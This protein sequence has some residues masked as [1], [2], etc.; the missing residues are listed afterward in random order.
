MMKRKGYTLVQF[1]FFMLMTMA[2]ATLVIDIGFATLTRRQMQTA[3][4][5]AAKEALRGPNGPT[6]AQKDRKSVV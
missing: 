3:V 5:M 4:N 1:V 2:L 6:N